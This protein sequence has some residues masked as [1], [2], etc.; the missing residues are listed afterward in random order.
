M[1]TLFLGP[2]ELTAQNIERFMKYTTVQYS[3]WKITFIYLILM[4]LSVSTFAQGAK[5][6]QNPEQHI[7]NPQELPAL[8]PADSLADDSNSNLS[9]ELLT[10]KPVI[11]TSTK[12]LN[13][14][15]MYLAQ[16]AVYLGTQAET[17]EHHGSFDNMTHYIF[18]PVFDRDDFNYNIAKH[19]LSGMLYYQFYRYRGYSE[20]D[21]FTWTFLSSLAFEFLIETYTEP[22]SIQ[23]TYQTPVY[24]TIV[25]F[26]LER[27]S[28]N[29]RSHDFFFARCI[30]YLLNPFS[31]LP[32]HDIQAV[33]SVSKGNASLQVVWR[34]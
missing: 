5:S 8:L 11:P 18:E 30:G 12:L 13:F 14:G 34:F 9:Q 15:A 3:T 29:L 24:G 26:V 28:E 23:D 20:L 33:P 25:G 10:T 16:W 7:Q 1:P 4:F 27:T 17:I 22:P 2:R 19:S 21:A 6:P 31:L 32:K